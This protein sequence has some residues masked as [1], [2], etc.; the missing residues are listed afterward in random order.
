[1]FRLFVRCVR[2]QQNLFATQTNRIVSV[3]FFTSISIGHTNT[4]CNSNLNQQLQELKIEGGESKANDALVTELVRFLFKTLKCSKEQVAELIITNPELLKK[5]SNV[6]ENIKFLLK[7][8]VKE[9]VIIDNPKMLT[10]KFGKMFD[11]TLRFVL[12]RQITFSYRSIEFEYD[13]S[14]SYE[15][16]RHQ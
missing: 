5:E 9:S 2:L 6:M 11:Y 10:I 14:E 7:E 3:N 16:Q 15:T 12:T 8:G 13:D 4:K 1:M